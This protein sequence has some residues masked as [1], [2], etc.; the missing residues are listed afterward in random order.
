MGRGWRQRIG[1]VRP[2]S[3]L[4]IIVVA[5]R[6]VA[7]GIVAIRW[8]GRHVSRVI[9]IIAIQESI[10]FCLPHHLLV[11][12][13]AGTGSIVEGPE[14]AVRTVRE[15]AVTVFGASS[16]VHAIDC[17][18]TSRIA[19]AAHSQALGR[20]WRRKQRPNQKDCRQKGK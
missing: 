10:C 16:V 18:G 14:I 20:N 3:G 11:I 4:P 13:L 2:V 15:I 12:L 5:I 8:I 19:I 17:G 7:I 1:P 9:R 6:I